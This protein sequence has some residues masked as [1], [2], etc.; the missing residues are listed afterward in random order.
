MRQRVT[1]FRYNAIIR[2]HLRTSRADQAL[3]HYFF[4]RKDGLLPDNFTISSLLKLCS[5]LDSGMCNCKLIHAF[6]IRSGYQQDVFVS[7]GLVELYLSYGDH[8]AAHQLFAEIDKRDVISWT[9][10]ISGLNRNSLGLESLELFRRMVKEGVKPNQATL[11]GVLSACKQLMQH[12]LGKSIHGILIRSKLARDVVIETALMDVYSKCRNLNYAQRVFDRMGERNMVSWTIIVSAYTTEGLPQTAIQMFRQMLKEGTEALNM[13][14][15]A[16]VLQACAEA[17]HLRYGREIHGRLF[18]IQDGEVKVKLINALIDMYVESSKLDY[19]FSLFRRMAVRNVVT[20]TTMIKGYGMHGLSEKALE[21]FELMLESG[22]KPD[23]ITFMAVLSSC[24]HAGLVE[25]GLKQFRSMQQDY[26]I[27]P[28]MRHFASIVDIFGR[29][30]RLKEAYDFIK[31][32]PIEPSEMVWTALLAACRRHKNLELGEFSAAE[33]LRFNQHNAGIYILL[34]HIYADLGRWENVSRVRL[35]MKKLRLKTNTACSWV[36]VKGKVY[37][38]TVSDNSQPFSDGLKKFLDKLLKK[39]EATGYMRSTSGVS[40]DT[41]EHEKMQ[42]LCG[43]CEKLA[44]AFALNFRVHEMPL[45]ISKNLRVCEDCHEF[46]KFVSQTFNQ[47]IFLKDPNRYHHFT[48]G[49]CS[50][51]DYW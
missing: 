4:M 45:R 19:A 48:Q 9:S 36:E 11:A 28:N 13:E 32:M 47:E 51:G 31:C 40:H 22:I 8:E 23:G 26:D 39:M 1:T 49:S 14:R 17:A 18:K 2:N 41:N 50:C 33:A 21:T 27:T 6:A 12:K 38:F 46:F 43:H 5:S 34:S 20:W 44:L 7:T 42:T 24:S 15:L 25:E 10:M 3:Q 16:P 37:K 35:L 30:G 29:A